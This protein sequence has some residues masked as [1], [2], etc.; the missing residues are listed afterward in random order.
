[1]T[2]STTESEFIMTKA[3]SKAVKVNLVKAEKPVVKIEVS[4]FEIDLQN[5]EANATVAENTAVVK[6][7]TAV[8]KADVAR[9]IFNESYSMNP[10][11]QRKDI[12][13]RFVAEAG[14]TKMGA[15]T[16]LQNFKDKAG[17]SVKKVKP[18][19]A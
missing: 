2:T 3:K 16:Y 13:N 6:T 4:Q 11:P 8:T 7:V 19:T 1:M 14:L 12:I 5:A 15:A 18:V 10:V 9:A 17:Y